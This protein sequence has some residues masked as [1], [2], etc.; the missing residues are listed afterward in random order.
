MDVNIKPNFPIHNLKKCPGLQ[1]PERVVTAGAAATKISE[2]KVDLRYLPCAFVTTSVYWHFSPNDTS[3]AIKT[4][5][6]T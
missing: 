6:L 5:A 1:W 2:I 4:Y 3:P